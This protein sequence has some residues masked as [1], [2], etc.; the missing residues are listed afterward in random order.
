[1]SGEDLQERTLA[2]LY[3]VTQ[4]ITSGDMS[5]HHLKS[6]VNSHMHLLKNRKRCEAFSIFVEKLVGRK[7]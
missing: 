5:T 6:E 1:M 3:K 4:N 2:M 7:E